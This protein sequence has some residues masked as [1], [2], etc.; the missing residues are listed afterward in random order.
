MKTYIAGPMSGYP[1]FNRLTFEAEAK[2]QA[3]QGHVVL[4]PHILP[5]GLSQA[6]YMQIDLQMVMVAERIVMLPGWEK[7][8]GARAEHAL[9]VKL[10]YEVIHLDDEWVEWGGGIR[11]MNRNCVVNVKTRDGN[12]LRENIADMYLWEHNNSCGDIIAYQVIK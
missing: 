7:S 3:E 5:D 12:I 11:P 4:S 6:E 1:E 8:A 2:R 9:A 10:G